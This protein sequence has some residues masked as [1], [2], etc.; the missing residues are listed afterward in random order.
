[1]SLEAP[2]RPE[3]PVKQSEPAGL[4]LTPEQL[5]ELRRR[6]DHMEQLLKEAKN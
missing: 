3:A 4:T 1:M 6:L 5:A 2:R